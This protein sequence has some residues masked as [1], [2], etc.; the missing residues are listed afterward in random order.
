MSFARPDFTRSA[1]AL[2]IVFALTLSLTGLPHAAYALS[3]LKPG[4][5]VPAQQTETPEAQESAE[6]LQIEGD[7]QGIPMPDPL[8][9]RTTGEQE[10]ASEQDNAPKISAEIQHDISKAPEPVRRLRQLII[11]AASTGDIEKLRPL[12]N[13]GP[14]QTRIEGEGDDPVAILKSFSGDPEGLEV[15]A[16][17]LDLLSTGYAHVDAGTPDEMYIFPYFAGKA[18]NTLTP[19]EKVELLRIITAGD[20]ADMQDYGNYSFYRIGISPDGQWKFFGAGD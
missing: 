17:I 19:P 8:V 20:L 13:P 12:I 15:L 7:A 18:L 2:S 11:D 3:E 6:P 16:I 5:G 9:N 1:T 14:N 4:P 10:S